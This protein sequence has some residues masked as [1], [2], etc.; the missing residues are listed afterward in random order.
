MI[1]SNS[2]GGSYIGIAS[3]SKPIGYFGPLEFASASPIG[4]SADRTDPTYNR[5]VKHARFF[6]SKN[7][8]SIRSTTNNLRRS[9]TKDSIS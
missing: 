7:V 5:S 2:T 3:A 6:R 1:A 9:T 8:N 4:Y